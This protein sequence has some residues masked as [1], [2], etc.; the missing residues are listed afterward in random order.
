[1]ALPLKPQPTHRF[2][3]IINIEERMVDL[4]IDGKTQQKLKIVVALQPVDPAALQAKEYRMAWDDRQNSAWMRFYGSYAKAFGMPG[5]VFADETALKT[6][7]F[8]EIEEVARTNRD[9]TVNW[10]E[11]VAVKGFRD[12][13]TCRAAWQEYMAARQHTDDTEAPEEEEHPAAGPVATNVSAAPRVPDASGIA[14]F[15]TMMGQIG[16]DKVKEMIGLSGFDADATM[17]L[18]A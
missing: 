14:A 18:M 5:G 17:K 1:M 8:V 16:A 15:K 10:T 6:Q 13:A 2:G 9:S 11:I 7:R 4:N 12:E 3:Q